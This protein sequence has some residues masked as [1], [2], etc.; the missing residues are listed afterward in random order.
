MTRVRTRSVLLALGLAL[1]ALVPPARADLNLD[2]LIC[3]KPRAVVAADRALE[4]SRDRLQEMFTSSL[5]ARLPGLRVEELCSNTLVFRVALALRTGEEGR[6]LGYFGAARLELLR[7]AVMT[8]DMV[9][10]EITVWQTMALLNGP[11]GDEL[12]AVRN[13][14]NGFLGAFAGAYQAAGNP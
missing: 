2:H 10:T 5:R 12:T 4:L 6:V 13:A 11:P 1:I 8:D 3:V 7:T 14:L 9:R